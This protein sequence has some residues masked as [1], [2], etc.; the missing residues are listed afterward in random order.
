M[1]VAEKRQSEKVLRWKGDDDE[2]RVTMRWVAFL[3]ISCEKKR[4]VR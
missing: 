3:I 1:G 4:L 2:Q